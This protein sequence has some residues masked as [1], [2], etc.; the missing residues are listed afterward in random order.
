MNNITMKRIEE[1]TNFGGLESGMLFVSTCNNL[2][3]RI[4]DELHDSE[5][6]PVNAI[7][8]KDGTRYFFGYYEK[9]YKVKNHEIKITY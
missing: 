7:K 9:V 1:S 6:M 2:F 3:I 4:E 5:N 8:I